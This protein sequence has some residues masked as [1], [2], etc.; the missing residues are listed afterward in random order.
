MKPR[1]IKH[2]RRW[3]SGLFGPVNMIILR[4][5]FVDLTTSARAYWWFW[6]PSQ[7]SWWLCPV[8]CKLILHYQKQNTH[9]HMLN[10]PLCLCVCVELER[11]SYSE[12][13]LSLCMQR[14]M[15]RLRYLFGCGVMTKALKKRFDDLVK[16]IAR[17]VE[18]TICFF[19]SV[20]LLLCRSP[21]HHLLLFLVYPLFL[22]RAICS[23][24]SEG[25]RWLGAVII[26]PATFFIENW[27]KISF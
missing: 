22:S 6:W 2:T 14:R 17:A 18:Q 20:S 25:K 27:Y 15:L 5:R 3:K 4:R 9:T 23:S 16:E 10:K 8:H 7:T 12:Y 26:S 1:K 11:E 19:W 13:H 24:F 21:H